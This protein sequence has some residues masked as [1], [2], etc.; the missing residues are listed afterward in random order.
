MKKD[1][2]RNDPITEWFVPG[3]FPSEPLFVPRAAEAGDTGVN[4]DDG[5]ILSVVWDGNTQA[6]YLL[7]LNATTMK[8]VASMYSIH[9]RST[10]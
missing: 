2:C 4:E 3:H 7:I 5:V 10:L 8:H 6:N 9:Q 1:I